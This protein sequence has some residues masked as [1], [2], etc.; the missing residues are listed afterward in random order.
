MRKRWSEYRHLAGLNVDALA[1]TIRSWWDSSPDGARGDASVSR[2]GRLVRLLF[3]GALIFALF[4]FARRLYRAGF[5][6]RLSRRE[7]TSESGSV[8]A[9]YQRM[10]ET[11]ESRGLQRA[12]H[13]TPLEFAA[14]TG[15]PEAMFLTRAYHRVR[16][17]GQKLSANEV[18]EVEQYLRRVEEKNSSMVNRQ[19]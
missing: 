6:R 12:A 1:A 17:G 8:V 5:M 11:L 19:S 9:F 3:A 7:E 14:A 15:I 18:A 13:Q 2:K 4:V 10:I 16:Y